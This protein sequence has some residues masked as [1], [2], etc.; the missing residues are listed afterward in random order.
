MRSFCVFSLVL[1]A[2]CA[3]A[4]PPVKKFE[5]N[6][7]E[8]HAALDNG[9]RIVLLPDSSS[10]LVAVVLRVAVGSAE[11]PPGKSGLA[12]L[13]EHLLFEIRPGGPGTAT[14]NALFR[15]QALDHNAYTA[16]DSTQY[17]SLA[18]SS[19]LESLLGFEA[20]RLERG[21]TGLDQATLDRDREIVK[22]ELREKMGPSQASA[23]ERVLSEAYPI[24]HP[25]RHTP[26][27][28]EADLDSV[29]LA[30]VC[31]FV[32]RYYAPARAVISVAGNV[33]VA[34]ADRALDASLARVPA[35]APAPR[36]VVPP[37]L[38]AA[39][40]VHFDAD[41][42]T[43]TLVALTP[44]PAEDDELRAAAEMV[45][46]WGIGGF[47]LSPGA[48]GFSRIPKRGFE[49]AEIER[50][51]ED[52]RTTLGRF[53]ERETNFAP[54][55]TLAACRLLLGLEGLLARA[56]AYAGLAANGH[57]PG[58]LT[59]ELQRIESISADQAT[60][61]VRYLLDPARV[62]AYV[63]TPAKGSTAAAEARPFAPA[64][65]PQ[66]DE[67]PV[68]AGEARGPLAVPPTTGEAEIRSFQL[69]NGLR[70]VLRRMHGPVP[71]ASARLSFAVGSMHDPDEYPGMAL[72]AASAI[73][74]PKIFARVEATGRTVPVSMRV[75]ID[76]FSAFGMTVTGAAA[77]DRTTFAGRGLAKDQGL[78]LEGLA[79]M[80]RKAE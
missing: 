26:G 10:D 17:L 55:R 8:Q 54:L 80:V 5:L 43:R 21:C 62:V 65:D 1:V 51:V 75:P 33:D 63:L 30:D 49:R 23:L 39:R 25:Y 40:V 28:R 60:R 45:S 31:S 79:S 56:D 18:P 34:R 53:F 78:L 73:S 46:H 12:H 4:R 14:L 64:E 48:V 27:G 15:Q 70:V 57:G 32:E 20:T 69:D 66:P 61:A 44:L 72:V 71:V 74:R 58:L 7:P 29:T 36:A 68:D 19:E 50:L 77:V 9:M 52:E 22:N 37:G 76:G 41:I 3:T 59:N 16:L 67:L 38:T 2:A 24:G 6:L 47:Q 13:V 35:R 42:A 11:D